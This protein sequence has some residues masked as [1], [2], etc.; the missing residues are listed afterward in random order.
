MN[1]FTIGEL[2]SASGIPRRTIY[3]YVQQGI[4][5]PP[6]GAGLAARYH[7]AHLNRL[8]AVPRFRAIGWRLDQIRAYFTQHSEEAIATVARGD[9]LSDRLLAPEAASTTRPQETVTLT[10]RPSYLA[11]YPLAPGVELLVA[12]DVSPDVAERVDRLLA[13]A[14]EI[15]DIHARG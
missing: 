13:H 1:E 6:A 7:A 12:R 3:F 5:P 4:L 10:P 14:V 2:E 9:S 8:R 15:F 11:R